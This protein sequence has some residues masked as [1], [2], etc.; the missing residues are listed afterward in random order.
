MSVKFGFL[1]SI[2][3][4]LGLAGCDTYTGGSYNVSMSTD[5]ILK[6][7]APAN[8][9]VEPF[10]VKS[11][12][13]MLCR[14]VGPINLPAGET[15][16][17]YLTKAFVDQF[18]LAGLSNDTGPQVSLTGQITKF[19]F[20]SMMGDGSWDL[21]VTLTSSNG[22]KLAASVSYPFG[23]S[24]VGDAACHNVAD[25]FEPAVQAL[26]KNAVSNPNFP[27]LLKAASPSVPGNV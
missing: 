26:V 19:S 17:S 22:Q 27:T 9:S 8:V 16:Q 13:S 20:D 21:A 2:A 3:V 5:M 24:F 12:P 11:D 15:P 4:C 6:K 18:E 14:L 10:T 1:V 7:L 25:A 23:A